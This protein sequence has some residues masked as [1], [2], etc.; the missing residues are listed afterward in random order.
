MAPASR[1]ALVT[2]EE[3]IRRVLLSSSISASA[4]YHFLINDYLL[5]QIQLDDPRSRLKFWILY[6]MRERKINELNM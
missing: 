4:I 6:T 2:V 3:G 5:Q 1:H